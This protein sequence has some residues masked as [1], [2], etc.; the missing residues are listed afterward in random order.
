MI[1]YIPRKLDYNILPLVDFCLKHNRNS[2]TASELQGQTKESSLNTWIWRS[3]LKLSLFLILDNLNSSLWLCSLLIISS[4]K[5]NFPYWRTFSN[6]PGSG[7]FLI[8]PSNQIFSL[9]T[10]VRL[11]PS[12]QEPVLRLIHHQCRFWIFT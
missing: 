3:G 9:M 12:I 2:G 1:K 7:I 6:I 11:Y 5:V 10:L 4:S 8:W